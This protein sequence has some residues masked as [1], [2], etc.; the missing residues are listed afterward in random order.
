MEAKGLGNINKKITSVTSQENMGTFDFTMDQVKCRFCYESL[1]NFHIRNI[2]INF[3]YQI[4]HSLYS[5]V[6]FTLSLIISK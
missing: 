4:K 3:K 6:S 5:F 1:L 2:D